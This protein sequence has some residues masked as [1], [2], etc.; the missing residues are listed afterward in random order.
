MRKKLGKKVSLF[1]VLVFLIS[2]MLS[3]FSY[4]LVGAGDLVRTHTFD[5]GVGL[6]WHVVESYPAKADFD[7]TGGTYNITVKNPAK[8]RWDIQF[9]HRGLTIENGHTYT[10][11]FT[12]TA[13][14]DCSI[15]SQIGEQSSPY[16]QFWNY[17]QNFSVIPL[18]ANTP[19]TITQPFTMTAATCKTA[20]WAFQLAGDL[21]SASSLPTFKFDNM[22]LLD[23]RFPGYPDPI[24]EPTNGVRVNQ[25]GYF[26][27]LSKVATLVSSSTAPVGW[28]LVNSAGTMVA[29]G[30]STV[31]GADKSS[32][33]NVHIIDFSSYKTEGTGYKLIADS[34]DPTA[35]PPESLPFDIRKNLYT[36]MKYNA[37]KYFYH[38]RSGIP[39]TMPYAEGTQWTRLAGHTNDVL[40]PDPSKDY[41]ADYTLDV[42][43]G[44][45]DAGDHGKYIVNGG[46]STW[47]VMNEYERALYLGNA[48]VAPFA[49]NT[50]NIPESGNGKPDILD[51]SRYNVELFL[52]MQVPAGNTLAGMVHH[53]AH[54]EMWT[55]LAIRP[56]QDTQKR[57]LQPPST[58]AT[59]NFAA[60][61]SQASRLWKQYDSAFA[62]KCLTAAE[63]AWVAAVA[64]PAIFASMDQSTGGGAYG[65]N[66]VQDDFYWAACELYVTTGNTKYLDY[67]KSSTHYLK[68]PTELTG[69]EDKGLTG[70]FDWGNTAG[71]GTIS[72]ALVPN[73][74]PA[75]DVATAQTN[76]KLA[77][78][79]FISIANSQG[80]GV[81]IEEK[82]LTDTLSG[83][84]WGSN[85][86]V[87]NEAIVMSY[88]YEFSGKKD[89]KY[90]SGAAGAMDYILGR[91]PNVQ[92][93]V[94][95]YGENPLENPHHRFWA[96]QADNTFP[97]APPG[98]LSGGPNSGLQDPWVK[99]SGWALGSRAPEKCFMDNIESWSTNEITIN[100]NAPL[101]WVSAYLDEQGPIVISGG[102]RYGDINKDGNKDA[103]DFALLRKYLL[104]QDATGLDLKA[105]DVNA[106]TFVDAVD[107]ALVKQYLLGK[108]IKFPAEG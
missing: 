95:G 13:S 61:T 28:K 31:K 103:L 66:Y 106:D 39:I 83:F 2:T 67:I 76:I 74:L 73:N 90:L 99:G 37:M 54:D 96:Y 104:T 93:Y 53:K 71:L 64:H 20:E 70:C 1:V 97:K 36:S 69:G 16:T 72:L 98:C 18:K 58:A 35:T 44:W 94:T 9:R 41:K 7:I 45:Y 14:K 62:A 86:F 92:S 89:T 22:Y 105:A 108:I 50:L 79:K 46:I 8:N 91:N 59:L 48:T 24:P 101:A 38:S 29:Q 87:V 26:P 85:S 3:S 78:D 6:P 55:A 19:T 80:Y 12:V 68:M 75:T 11:K 82:Q 30:V 25:E 63:T 57:Y 40:G 32:G 21:V 47:T 49:D 100:W 4:A 52:K 23:P 10:V 65:D 88:A 34:S 56:D 33:D 107:Y 77:A 51:E 42:T 84:P 15:Y 5:D 17:N 102:P 81:P 60:V 43:G 27:E